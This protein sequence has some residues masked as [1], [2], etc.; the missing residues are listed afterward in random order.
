MLKALETNISVN[1]KGYVISDDPNERMDNY[2][3]IAR[4]V[5][6]F[7]T[8]ALLLRESTKQEMNIRTHSSYEY[9]DFIPD[10]VQEAL[11]FYEFIHSDNNNEENTIRIR[12]QI[13]LFFMCLYD[14]FVYSKLYQEI[15][16]YEECEKI[17]CSL[18]IF[19]PIEFATINIEKYNQ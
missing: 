5:A 19:D 6:Q 12:K 14:I 13:A 8:V 7:T 4:K 1:E 11:D 17:F 16:L 2:T 10:G 9:N 18:D 3:S 15:Y